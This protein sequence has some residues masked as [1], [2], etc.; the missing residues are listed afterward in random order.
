MKE[1]QTKQSSLSVDS[2]LDP[3]RYS[4]DLHSMSRDSTAPCFGLASSETLD[5]NENAIK[6]IDI[7]AQHGVIHKLSN[8]EHNYAKWTVS[9]R[10]FVALERAG[11]KT[12]VQ[13]P[14]T[15]TTASKDNHNTVKKKMFYVSFSNPDVKCSSTYLELVSMDCSQ[16]FSSL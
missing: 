2:H 11:R 13:D 10:Y 9:P 5:P 1:R 6:Y 16:I 15:L 14:L 8:L 7:N 12:S 4:E 3:D